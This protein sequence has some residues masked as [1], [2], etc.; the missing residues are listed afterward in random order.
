MTE[1]LGLSQSTPPGVGIRDTNPSR[2]I[3]LTPLPAF[4]DIQPEPATTPPQCL[5][6]AMLLLQMRCLLCGLSK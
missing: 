1:Q 4:P 2:C 5:S 3:Q 6:P